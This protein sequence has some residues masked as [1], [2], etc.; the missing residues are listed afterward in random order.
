[1][2][3]V[4]STNSGD[5]H[6][7]QI[8][9]NL[10]LFLLLF[11][12]VCNAK[13]DSADLLEITEI[14]TTRP[15]LTAGTTIGITAELKNVSDS[16]L[17]IYEGD[18]TLVL[19][20]ELLG[21]KEEQM[22]GWY[23]NF[24]TEAHEENWRFPGEKIILRPGAS[25]RV[26]WTNSPQIPLIELRYTGEYLTRKKI[27]MIMGIEGEMLY[28]CS[29]EYKKWDSMRVSTATS[30][31]EDSTKLQS[32]KN[33]FNKIEEQ[34]N[35]EQN[36]VK[37]M[38]RTDLFEQVQDMITRELM[39]LFFNPGEYKVIVHVKYATNDRY[40]SAP[41]KSGQA[42]L[43][44]S[45][46]E[47]KPLNVGGYRITS[48]SRM[49][50]FNAP[51]FV[52]LFG[53]GLGG[54]LSFVLLSKGRYAGVI[55]WKQVIKFFFGALFAM[56]MSIVVTILISRIAETQF[57]VKVTI[58]DLWGAIAVG[59]II[60]YYGPKVLDQLF[61]SQGKLQ[62]GK[63]VERKE[64]PQESEPDENISEQRDVESQPGR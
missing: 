37:N 61:S 5:G 60:N 35:S 4:T 22:V 38:I 44:Q 51:Q 27:D 41:Q 13:K 6:T 48:K 17:I 30:A 12:A 29:K 15:T 55:W 59:F 56:L 24:P 36:V 34:I 26:V 28:R 63:K 14:E 3:Y 62:S 33:K 45:Y 20:Q 21:P 31:F 25:Y 46:F 58:N 50:Y 11:P 10:L 53:A 16:T 9:I 8:V 39:F 43:S 1:M 47:S 2:R 7:L 54:V 42:N 40:P 49:L 23:G 19:P 18:V 64:L 32:I 52:I 57:F